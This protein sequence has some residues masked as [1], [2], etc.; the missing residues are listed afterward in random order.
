MI[1]V[2]HEGVGKTV[3]EGLKIVKSPYN[4]FVLSDF[5]DLWIFRSGVAV[6]KAKVPVAEFFDGSDPGEGDAGEVVLLE[7]PDNFFS[8][9]DLEEAVAVPRG[10]EGVAVFQ[11]DR[12]EALAAEG[13]RAVSAGGVFA[14]KG[15]GEFP[16]DGAGGIIFFHDLIRLMGDEKVPVLELANQSGVGVGAGLGNL[17][18]DFADDLF[19]RCDLDDAPGA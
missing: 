1:T 5:N 7:L 15:D 2:D 9:C 18:G 17:Q 3:A 10:D 16:D 11:A 14:E 19:P 8:W 12:G 13:L 6:A 4:L